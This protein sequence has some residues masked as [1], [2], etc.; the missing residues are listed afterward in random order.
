[1]LLTKRILALCLFMAVFTGSAA[2]APQLNDALFGR[3]KEVMMLLSYGEYDRAFE[4]AAFSNPNIS[5]D[6]FKQFANDNF[7]DLFY[8]S[9]Q[10]DVA[11]FCDNGTS[12]ILY[13]P[14]LTPSGAHG[15]VF[16]LSST[17]G[18]TFDGYG[19]AD[20]SD[21]QNAAA[22]AA[23]AVWNDAFANSYIIETDE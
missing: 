22:S 17:D 5:A 3:G 6:A 12:W 19:C 21:V 1:M 16:V 13:I 10:R 4:K 11:V 23:S 7:Y 14:V 20:W 18:N 8:E 15:E 9:P 2:A